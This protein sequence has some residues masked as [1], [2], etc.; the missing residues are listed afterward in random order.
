MHHWQVT[1]YVIEIALQALTIIVLAFTLWAI[2]RQ[3]RAAEKLTK[4]TDQQIKTGE[5]QAK[6]AREQVDVAKRQIAESLRPILTL[7]ASALASTIDG[8][9]PVTDF[10][11][12]NEGAGAAL[13]VW[14]SCGKYGDD[15]MLIQ[16]R[17]LQ[18]GI[19][20]SSRGATFSVR[21]SE[22][23]QRQVVIVYTSLAGIHSATTLRW[24]GREWV[25]GYIA[26]AAKWASTLPGRKPES[27]TE[28]P[29]SL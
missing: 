10:E 20:P 26:D 12:Q 9:P 16:Q 15:F 13:N 11:V 23:V 6:A 2:V 27:L 5:E 28:S 7:R 18:N 21:D 22:A 4:A 1:K 3:A 24:D 29:N 19:I 8:F 14:W 25:P 17:P